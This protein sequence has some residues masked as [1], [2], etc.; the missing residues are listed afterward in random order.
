MWSND[1]VQYKD[2]TY[3]L[4]GGQSGFAG[5][6]GCLCTPAAVALQQQTPSFGTL[7]LIF[8]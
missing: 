7:D 1:G 4:Q 2:I 6:A 5:S 3:H 8:P